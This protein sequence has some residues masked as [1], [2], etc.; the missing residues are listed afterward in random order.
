[1]TDRR[2]SL[3]FLASL[4]CL[5]S[6]PLTAQ[7]ARAP[8][9]A[10]IGLLM[11]EPP[12]AQATRRDAL[13]AGL[14][15]YGH[16]EGRNLLLVTRSADGDYD[17]LPA[18]ARS[19]VDERVDVIVAFG[20]KALAA[21]AQATSTI[22]IVIPATSGDPQSLG[23]V[24]DLSRPGRNVAGASAFGPEI[25]AKRLELVRELK[26]KL[27]RVAV[28]ANAA[29]A[30]TP[31]TIRRVESG[32]Q[33]HRIAVV[34]HE[35]RTAA[36]LEPALAAIAS[37]RA[38]AVLVQDDTLFAG[39]RAVALARRAIELG[40]AT[41]G[42]RELAEAGAL[43]GYGRTDDELYRRGGYFVHRILNGARPA[44]IPFEQASR[45]D[46]VVNARTARALGLRVPPALVARADR[47]I[48]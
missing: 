32:A 17:R 23:L 35:V 38:G 21:A 30:G 6:A 7:T 34:A 47:V 44:E 4:A 43:V 10:R 24:G 29:N 28:L 37:G 5:A 14:A 1:M 26:P 25:M 2:R 42:N 33:R 20:I 27:A 13:V 3:A 11:S 12:A 41:A 39:P 18:L 22:P 9:V 15:D 36:D 19:L 8:G 48:E 40:L 31:A 45:F 16:V 46:V